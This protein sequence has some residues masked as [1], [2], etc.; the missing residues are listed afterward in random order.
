MLFFNMQSFSYVLHQ[1]FIF[2]SFSFA[3]G[4]PGESEA[5]DCAFLYSDRAKLHGKLYV[6]CYFLVGLLLCHVPISP[7]QYLFSNR[8]YF[9][10][11][12]A[13][14]SSA[15]VRFSLKISDY[16]CS[17]RYISLTILCAITLMYYMIKS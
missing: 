17:E 10:N 12:S 1:K 11:G 6:Q 8:N 15:L 3:A 16:D 9:I 13:E 4:N 7:Y 2:L 5:D 14:N